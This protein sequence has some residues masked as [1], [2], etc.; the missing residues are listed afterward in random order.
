MEGKFLPSW[1]TRGCLASSGI[2]SQGCRGKTRSE[3]ILSI[4]WRTFLNHSLC[5]PPLSNSAG[6]PYP[7]SSFSKSLVYPDLHLQTPLAAN[8]SQ[9]TIITIRND[10]QTS[11]VPFVDPVPLYNQ[12]KTSHA[13]DFGNT[14]PIE[15]KDAI[16]LDIAP[17]DTPVTITDTHPEADTFFDL[18]A[19][20][21][22]NLEQSKA[23]ADI[24]F[25][26]PMSL[27]L[28]ASALD[29]ILKEL[30]EVVI[31]F[32]MNLGECCWF[33]DVDFPRRQ[34][35]QSCLCEYLI[36]GSCVCGVVCWRG[37]DQGR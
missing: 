10:L 12:G 22:H 2:S 6:L 8:N 9:L 11:H 17:Q 37:V 5:L 36:A 27:C 25:E 16:A 26:G 21:I 18:P 7:S 1:V 3:K 33:E 19:D 13:K 31:E 34:H 24:E 29:S 15:N 20:V 30:V 28:R 23:L 4:A 32:H 35:T 14:I